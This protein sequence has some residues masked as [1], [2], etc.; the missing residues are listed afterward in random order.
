M[1]NTQGG[2]H[3]ID[4]VQNQEMHLWTEIWRVYSDVQN[5]GYT[6]EREEQT[7]QESI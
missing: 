7:L 1:K 6:Q 2:R 4:N 3:I 5:A